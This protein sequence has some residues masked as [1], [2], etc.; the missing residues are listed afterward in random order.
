MESGNTDEVIERLRKSFNTFAKETNSPSVIKIKFQPSFQQ[1]T[2]FAC[3]DSVVSNVL[4]LT[5]G[6]KNIMAENTS[7][8]KQLADLLSAED[9]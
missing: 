1:F 7:L 4:A 3:G 5:M 9:E 8:R 6:H 2:T